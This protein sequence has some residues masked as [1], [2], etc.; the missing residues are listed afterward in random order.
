MDL[1]VDIGNTRTKVALFSKGEIIGFY[2][3][4]NPFTEEIEKLKKRKFDRGIISSVS[5]AQ[6]IWLESFSSISWITLSAETRVPFK[7]KYETPRTL[8]LDRVALVAAAV[9]K[10]PNKNVLIIDAGT[11]VTY[12]LITAQGDYLGGAISP[13]LQMRLKAMHTFTSKLPLVQLNPEVSILGNNT[14]KSLQSGAIN[15]LAAELDG[16]ISRYSIQFE[17]LI[18]V[19]TGGDTKVLVPLVKSGI[20]A[21]RNFLLEGLHAILAFNTP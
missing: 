13:G 6:S 5:T 17:N 12:D 19:L 21:P 3:G 2:A 9:T 20:F 18:V 16:M 15:G 8:G 4:D 7:N 11:C 10:Y 14:E 1:I